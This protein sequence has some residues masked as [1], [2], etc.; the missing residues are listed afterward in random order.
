MINDDEFIAN[1]ESK[2]VTNK[3]SKREIF[4]NTF[5]DG[6]DLFDL[7]DSITKSDCLPKKLKK[8][9]LPST[10]VTKAGKNV[11]TSLSPDRESPTKGL[12]L[13]SDEEICYSN[14]NS[15]ELPFD[16]TKK[17]KLPNITKN[18]NGKTVDIK[19]NDNSLRDEKWIVCKGKVISQLN[20]LSEGNISIVIEELTKLISLL[21]IQSGKLPYEISKD[22]AEL[23]IL[24][25]ISNEQLQPSVIMTY[26]GIISWLSS[27][28]PEIGYIFIG[29][30]HDLVQ[31]S[32]TT[33][34]NANSN[35]DKIIA[36]KKSIAKNC[37]ISLASLFHFG[38]LDIELLCDI[39]HI[40]TDCDMNDE[41]SYV[42]I[43]LIRYFGHV[44][45]IKSPQIIQQ[46]LSQIQTKIDEY[47]TTCIDYSKSVVRF[48]EL[49]I[50]ERK[51]KCNT[52]PLD[53]LKETLKR[54]CNISVFVSKVNFY[55][56]IN[57]PH[58][59]ID[60][61]KALKYI[62]T[63]YSQLPTGQSNETKKLLSKAS[64]LGLSNST[65][66]SVFLTLMRSHDSA[67]AFKIITDNFPSKNNILNIVKTV[68]TC[69]LAERQFN[70]FYIQVI[71]QLNKFGNKAWNKSFKYTL[72]C[73]IHNQYINTDKFSKRKKRILQ[74]AI[75]HMNDKKLIDE[76]AVKS[77]ENDRISNNNFDE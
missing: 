49:E 45:H 30:L 6:Q 54:H 56:F 61:S 41:L 46:I 14:D 75:S 42:I 68:I 70:P 31:E 35:D 20:R 28:V 19:S 3:Q 4:S 33:L 17:R 57:S 63:D 74:M 72:R 59:H 37:I 77:V 76:H 9:T 69:L 44:V 36:S 2:Y 1:Y 25:S 34:V 71:E 32:T 50:C 38:M 7:L 73:T 24:F 53:N 16:Y 47:K 55:N 48:L 29:N 22:L 62:S 66:K 27:L 13:E 52:L 8:N 67:Q 43:T 51:L 39:I 26:T 11:V 40:I 60:P 58:R 10:D 18:K 21:N 12:N 23:I 15:K 65:Q 64:S 5:E